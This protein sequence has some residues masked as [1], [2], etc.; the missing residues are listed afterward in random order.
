MKLKL[1][2]IGFVVSLAAFGFNI[3][4]AYAA[5]FS[6]SNNVGVSYTLTIWYGTNR[7]NVVPTWGGQGVWGGGP[8]VLAPPGA[9]W[10]MP[11][12]WY[13]WSIDSWPSGYRLAGIDGAAYQQGGNV[14]W[15]VRWEADAPPVPSV[16]ISADSTSLPY[17]GSTTIRW[18]VSPSGDS[19]ISCTAGG[20]KDSWH[21]PIGNIGYSSPTGPLYSTQTY[22]VTCSSSSGSDPDDVRVNVAPPQYTLTVSKN[23]SGSGTV[24]GGSIINCGSTCSAVF[25]SGD[26]VGLDAHSDSGSVFS[27]WSGPCSG[28]GGCVFPITSNQTVYATFDRAQPTASIT[29]SPGT[30]SYNSSANVSWSSTNSSGCSV[31]PAGWTGKSGSQSTGNLTSSQTYTVTCTGK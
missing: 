21:G 28:T 16:N 5:V 8:L 19:R 11:D 25:N 10:T 27:G 31:S 3:Q 26:M 20:T 1:F 15:N 30:V 17:G 14:S 6:I 7:N 4:D 29:C 2:I 13:T 12:G 18:S 23:G 9:S 22:S 24:R